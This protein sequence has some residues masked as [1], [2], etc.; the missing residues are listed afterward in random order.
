MGMTKALEAAC[1]DARRWGS[2]FVMMYATEGG[3]AAEHL[4]WDAVSID[5][6]KL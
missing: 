2:G 3:I 5:P 1:A 4:D 6:E